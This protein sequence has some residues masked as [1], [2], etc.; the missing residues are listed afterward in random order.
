M[1]KRWNVVWNRANEILTEIPNVVKNQS[2]RAQ[3]TANKE[4]KR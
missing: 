2:I 4:S 3:Q 1:M